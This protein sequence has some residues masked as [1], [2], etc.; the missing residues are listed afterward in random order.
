MKTFAKLAILLIY[1]LPF[2]SVGA[3]SQDDVA[4]QIQAYIQQMRDFVA[5]TQAALDELNQHYANRRTGSMRDAEAKIETLGRKALADLDNVK[6]L[7][8]ETK[9]IEATRD[10][11][12]VLVNATQD[13]LPKITNRYHL[14]QPTQ[15][16]SDAVVAYQN[17][18]NKKWSEADA[19]FAEATEALFVQFWCPMGSKD[20]CPAVKAIIDDVPNKFENLK[21][22]EDEMVPSTWDCKSTFPGAQNCRCM[23]IMNPTVTIKYMESADFQQ[24]ANAQQALYLYMKYCGEGK[25]VFTKDRLKTQAKIDAE[26]VSMYTFGQDGTWEGQIS[27]DKSYGKYR[28]L[29]RFVIEE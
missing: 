2:G 12:I 19:K 10:I 13:E 27:V 7:F 29:L 28:L 18:F 3:Q 8:G 17:Q 26:E 23:F 5:P 4:Q 25:F 16:D 1:L 24:I 21:G 14:A 11:L 22:K 9:L 15:A 6:P 20:L